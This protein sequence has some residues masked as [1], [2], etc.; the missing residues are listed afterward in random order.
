MKDT[1]KLPTSDIAMLKEWHYMAET[2]RI[3]S[4]EQNDDVI[5]FLA[6]MLSTQ[7]Y[8]RLGETEANALRIASG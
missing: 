7:I 5:S 3:D 6:A 1:E 8:E 2:I 4:S